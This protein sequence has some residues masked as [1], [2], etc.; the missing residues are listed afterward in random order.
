[1]PGVYNPDNPDYFAQDGSNPAAGN[2]APGGTTS[3]PT[4]EAPGGGASSSGFG[5]PSFGS[6]GNNMFMDPR[7]WAMEA[8]AMQQW[9]NAG[10]YEDLGNR[11]A[12]RA[13][14]FGQYR[15]GYGDMLKGLYD[16]PSKIADTPGYK[17]A[18]NQ[19][20]DATQNRLGN[21]GFLGSSQM[22]SAL[23][24]QA[25]GMAQQ[26]W[27]TERNALMQMSGAQF[28]PANAA[29][30]MMEGGKLKVDAQNQALMAALYPFGHATSTTNINNSNGGGQ[31][32][33]NNGG[34]KNP[35]NYQNYLNRLQ[36]AGINPRDAATLLRMLIS[37]PEGVSQADMQILQDTGVYQDALGT[38]GVDTA[39][40]GYDYN[41][42]AG[43]GTAT[44]DPTLQGTNFGA[45]DNS[46]NFNFGQGGGDGTGYSFMQP[47][48]DYG[49]GFDLTG[50]YGGD[51]NT[52]YIG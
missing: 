44:G 8:Q 12:D 51:Y 6:G 30:M 23:A 26:T 5:L 28:D 52:D 38:G 45:P 15:R 39:P 19:A 16:D 42:F 41:G 11:A 31:G 21:Q 13:D 7:F 29:R 49:T 27:N 24:A 25:S 33:G 3:M 18:L 47:G 37:N 4:V 17:F 32:G 48:N 9:H 2:V 50:G 35:Y 14:P 1:M 43:Y 20:L 10:Q 40:P 36:Q 46:T 34:I 22:Q